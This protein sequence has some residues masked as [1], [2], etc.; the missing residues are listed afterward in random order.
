VSTR[1]TSPR[2]LERGDDRTGF[3][4]GADELDEWLAKYA[5]QN[6]RANNAITYVSLADGRVVGYY[7]ITVAAYARTE[8]P[9][10]V[11]KG[12]PE[13]V[14]CL[15][16]ARLAVDRE[17]QGH[18]LGAGLLRDA[19]ERFVVLADS[20]GARCV[21]VHARDEEARAFYLSQGDFLQSPVDRLHLLAP[22][23]ALRDHFGSAEPG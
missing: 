17:W 16:L 3:Q 18:G 23:K 15:L 2:K 14:P 12:A 13:Q 20:V 11:A 4:S 6:Q 10:V 9:V 21:L 8:A 1:P 22:I 7:A 19:L 5:W